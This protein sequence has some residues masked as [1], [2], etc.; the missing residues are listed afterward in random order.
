MTNEQLLDD[1]KQFVDSKVSQL[2]LSMGNN[3]KQITIE[4][5]DEFSEIRAEITNGFSG[6]GDAIEVIH[7]ALADIEDQTSKRLTKL[8]QAST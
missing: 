1:L 7:D 6:V 8:E 2:E 4:L 5:A 3:L